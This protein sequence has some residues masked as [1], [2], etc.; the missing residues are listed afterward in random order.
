M[1]ADRDVDHGAGRGGAEIEDQHGTG[2]T[3]E[4]G[5][6]A[7]GG[8]LVL[9]D[10]EAEGLGLDRVLTAG[11][12][13]EPGGAA[14]E[15]EQDCTAEGH[16]GEGG[17]VVAGIIDGEHVRDGETDFAAR[18]FGE[19]GDHLLQQEDRDQ[20]GEAK[21]GSAETEGRECQEK[22]AGDGEDGAE[23]DADGDGE[24][25]FGVGDTGPV[26]AE[27]DQEGG[28]EI[29]FTGEAEQQVPAHGEDGEI[30]AEGE[31]AQ[32]VAGDA[33]GQQS[34][35]EQCREGGVGEWRAHQRRPRMPWGRR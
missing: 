31:K 15:A 8:E 29:D 14:G 6:D 22:A 4:E 32:D 10:V 20:R 26:G 27:A 16:E 33:E 11:L 24:A 25:P 2:E 34:E 9:G 35:D 3:A 23:D 30:E 13:D 7:E 28:A 19:D 21:I 17:E 18:V 12:Q 5:A 1:D